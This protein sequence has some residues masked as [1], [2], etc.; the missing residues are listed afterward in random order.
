MPKKIARFAS[1]RMR[2]A[3]FFQFFQSFGP[4][5]FQKQREG[6]V[7]EKFSSSLAARAVIGFVVGVADAL[8]G[9]AAIRTWFSVAAM[10]CHSLAE[11]G[12]MLGKCVAGFDAQFFNPLAERFLC[13]AVQALDLLARK[14]RSE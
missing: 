1:P 14:L 12:D 3:K 4:I 11:R 10:D 8:D 2:V 5:L 13:G 9:R 7:G 6:A